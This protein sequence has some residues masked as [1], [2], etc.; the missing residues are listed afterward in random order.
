MTLSPITCRAA[1]GQDWLYGVGGDDVLEG[2]PGADGM[3]GG[4]GND[5]IYADVAIA[6]ADAIN[7]APGS[8]LA[9]PTGVKGDWLYG[10]AGDD[11]LA[12]VADNEVLA[13]GTGD[14]LLIGGAGD[15]DLLGDARSNRDG[16]TG[17]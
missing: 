1:P 14:D 8:A 4:S 12:G 9:T 5:R 10:A 2:G 15:D 7:P 3:D 16:S 13:G 6:L 17:A 11:I